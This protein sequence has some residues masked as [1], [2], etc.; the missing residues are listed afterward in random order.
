MEEP[1]ENIEEIDMPAYWRNSLDE[2]DQLLATSRRGHVET[3]G[4]SAG[5]RPIPAIFYGEKQPFT[6][7]ANYS[8]A[9]GSGDL[10]RY[11]C[12][13]K[14]TRPV[15]LII[16]GIHGGELEGITAI[17]N[18]IQMIET[19]RDFGGCT[20]SSILNLLASFRLI[21]IPCMNPD[22]R[23]RVPYRSLV[24][25]S[26]E[27]MRYHL[28]G[29]WKDGSLCGWP[30]CKTVHP[31]LN[32]VEHLG[33]YFNDDGIN[34]MHDQFFAPMANETK[35]LM[36]LV[37]EEAADAIVQLH[38]GANSPN[39]ILAAS[40][41]PACIRER[42]NEFNRL[43]YNALAAYGLSYAPVFGDPQEGAVP[44]PP[45]FNLASALHH[46]CGGLSMVYESNMGLCAPGERYTYEQILESHYI[47]F[48]Q[49]FAYIKSARH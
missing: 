47:L 46:I 37:D 44:P 36:R 14:D 28:Q 17:M 6:R 16:G 3:I 38:G 9:C 10:T 42:Q 5:G 22:G 24:G 39:H 29:T 27:Q 11:A 49:L 1:I 13:T 45:S 20:R 19:G 32:H 23:A 8:S 12:K 15:I 4:Y 26:L 25:M 2:I 30:A 41:V 33:S 35:L 31:I 18:L 7:T 34:L 43:Y 21:L 48:E 40:Y